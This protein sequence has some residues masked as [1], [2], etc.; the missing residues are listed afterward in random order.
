[1]YH[2]HFQST[3]F[4]VPLKTVSD[5]EADQMNLTYYDSDVH[6]GCFMWP[7]FLKKVFTL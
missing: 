2:N 5:E 6:Q 3:D 7:R 1:M 4:R